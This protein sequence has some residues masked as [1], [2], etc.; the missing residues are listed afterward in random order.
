[1][2]LQGLH[3]VQIAIPKGGEDRARAFYHDLLGMAELPKAT[4]LEGRGG[5][6]FRLGD[7]EIHAGAD[8]AFALPSSKA[9][10]GFT[11]DD[12]AACRDRLAKAGVKLEEAIPIPGFTRFYG[13]DPFGLRIEF[14]Q[15]G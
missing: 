2:T 3:H 10:L 15:R 8:A 11:V 9:H 7:V 1:M 4:S 12:L 6:W 5:C 13:Y 14:L